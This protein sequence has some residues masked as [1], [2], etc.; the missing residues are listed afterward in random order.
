MEA[1]QFNKECIYLTSSINEILKTNKM[2][3]TD[4]LRELLLRVNTLE[5]LIYTHIDNR[6][7][8]LRKTA[9]IKHNHNKKEEIINEEFIC[10]ANL[11]SIENMILDTFEDELI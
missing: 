6:I 10:L 9:S 11:L 3:I 7:R 8:V 2:I 5:E 1:L 4:K